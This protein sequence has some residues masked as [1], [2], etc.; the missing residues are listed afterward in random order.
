MRDVTHF[1]NLIQ[2]IQDFGIKLPHASKP[3]VTCES[4]KTMSV[5][6]SMR[7]PTNFAQEL[8]TF[9]FNCITSINMHWTRKCWQRKFALHINVQMHLPKPHL[10]MLFHVCEARSADGKPL[11]GSVMNMLLQAAGSPFLP[12]AHDRQ[13]VLG[14]HAANGFWQWW[15]WGC[16][17][18]GFSHS[19]TSPTI[20]VLGP[21]SPQSTVP[22]QKRLQIKMTQPI[23]CPPRWVNATC[24]SHTLRL[25]PARPVP[26]L[27]HDGIHK[28]PQ[29]IVQ[30]PAAPVSP[31]TNPETK[32][33][34]QT[35]D[36]QFQV[37]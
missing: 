9:Q 27:I 3:K 5:P 30:I 26:E 23:S 6:L 14:R 31:Q 7:M 37:S 4:S 13:C 1:I 12:R 34:T 36:S 11:W 29:C 16:W 21:K 24:A 22:T 10:M 20:N 28:F 8:N 32:S 19:I 15:I 35:K 33:P 17:A 18:V 2:E 25:A